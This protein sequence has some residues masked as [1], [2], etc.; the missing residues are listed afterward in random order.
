MGHHYVP[1]K[2]LRGFAEPANPDAIWMYDKKLRKFKNPV[3]KR[4]AQESEFF[5]NEVERQLNELVEIPA[6]RV[7]NKLINQEIF[8]D[9]ERAQLA[10][11]IATTMKRVPR[12]RTKALAMLPGVIDNVVSEL[13]TKIQ[14]WAITTVNKNLV[15]RRLI[16]L[17]EA[18]ESLRTKTPDYIIEQIRLP[19]ANEEMINLIYTM[20]WRI[21]KSTGPDYFVTSDNPAYFFEGF[22]LKNLESEITFPITTDIALFAS[23]QGEKNS[24][25]YYFAKKVHIREANR[26]LI[27][28]A[29]RFVF[30]H[31]QADWIAKLSDKPKLFISRIRW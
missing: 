21:L 12:R 22:G 28:G 1:Q 17:E 3:I 26:R 14:E 23:W 5:D 31:Q 2:Y 16:E 20:P 4:V 27:S 8:N 25:G 9:T 18:E 13:R 10:I 24:V 30:Y 19:W 7:M 11:Y 15:Q 6:N 29:E